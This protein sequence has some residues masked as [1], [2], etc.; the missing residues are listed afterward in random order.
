MKPTHTH[1]KLKPVS[2]NV[3]AERRVTDNASSF[4]FFFYDMVRR[5]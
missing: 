3:K 4:S 5:K 1:T 2:F